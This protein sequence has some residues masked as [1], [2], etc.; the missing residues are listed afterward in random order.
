MREDDI[1][2]IL[3]W[4]ETSICSDGSLD[5]GHPRGYGAFTKYLHS[6]G[7]K[8]TPE[9]L[10]T[11]VRKMTG[12][13]AS[14]MGITD[15]GRIA[16]DWPADLVLFDPTQVS[17]RSTIEQPHAVSAGIRGVWVNGERVW[18]GEKPTGARPGQV[19]R[20]GTGK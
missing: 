15:R 9:S 1:A 11:A 16:K 17:D 14:Q 7:L 2:A 13:T 10:A 20:R 6:Y 8:G 18:D 12:L 4:P 19:V 5:G 3:A